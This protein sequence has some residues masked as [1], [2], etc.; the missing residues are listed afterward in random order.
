MLEGK[1][2]KVGGML[3]IVA[4]GLYIGGL[5]DAILYDIG[6]GLA[7]I[8]F[9]LVCIGIHNRISRGLFNIHDGKIQ[10]GSVRLQPPSVMG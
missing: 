9:G 3:L 4:G 7:M 1:K 2:T 10:Y 5:Y 6:T 8:G